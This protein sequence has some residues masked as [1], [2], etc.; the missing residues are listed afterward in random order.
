M[1]FTVTKNG[2]LGAIKLQYFFADLRK[3]HSVLLCD[4]DSQG[5]MGDTPSLLLNDGRKIKIRIYR[6]RYG[7]FFK[8]KIYIPNVTP[9]LIRLTLP[10]KAKL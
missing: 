6:S 1:L 9:Y 4:N 3:T 5:Y 7:F 8:K 2:P 10:L